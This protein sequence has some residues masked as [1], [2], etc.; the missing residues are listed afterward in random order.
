MRSPYFDPLRFVS[1]LR[2]SPEARHGLIAEAAY[3]RSKK[4]GAEPGNPIDDWL[5]AEQ[6]VD[7]RL[8]YRPLRYG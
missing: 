5:A 2:I 1:P 3:L 4:R 7:A 6:E 8:M